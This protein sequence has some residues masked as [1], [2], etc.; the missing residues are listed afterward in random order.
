MNKR[1]ITNIATLLIGAALFSGCQA[2]I[3]KEPEATLAPGLTKTEGRIV[4]EN[5]VEGIV[6]KLTDKTIFI[7]VEGVKWEFS[8]SEE[9]K[10]IVQK[11]EEHGNPVANGSY[12]MVHYEK[13][14]NGERI[15]KNISHVIVN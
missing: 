9:A 5:I 7:T 15:A 13:S 10:F 1:F 8:L 2:E 3:S 14:E 6:T 11:L 4:S 12:V